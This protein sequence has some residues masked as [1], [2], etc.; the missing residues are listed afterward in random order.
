VKCEEACGN[1]YDP[2]YAQSGFPFYRSVG[3][4]GGGECCS[5]EI[6]V[7][8][9][10]C[11]GFTGSV[12]RDGKSCVGDIACFSANI[13]SVVR[14]CHGRTSCQAA[15]ARDSNLGKVIDSCQGDF[16]CTFAAGYK[17]FSNI[18]GSIEEI[19]GSCKGTNACQRAA[20]S[21]SIKSIIGSCI[22]ESSCESIAQQGS[23][24]NIYKSCNGTSACT[25]AAEGVF[26]QGA[27]SSSI[28]GVGILNSCNSDKACYDLAKTNS[29]DIYNCTGTQVA[30]FCPNYCPEPRGRFGN[31]TA[32]NEC[33]DAYCPNPFDNRNCYN[34]TEGAQQ[35][36]PYCPTYRFLAYYDIDNGLDS[37]CNSDFE[38]EGI[39]TQDD[40]P[41]DCSVS[42]D[43]PIVATD[44]LSA[45]LPE[46]FSPGSNNKKKNKD[47]KNAP[48]K[49]GKGGD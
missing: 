41:D 3:G 19:I 26:N 37:C 22:G 9:S 17:E 45:K 30:P 46:D 35:V 49:K 12:C 47:K 14:S 43:L 16:S 28:G 34:C 27:N 5:G 8:T 1:E 4:W 13:S 31:I 25:A 11:Q 36:Y 42:A 24:E 38:C 15:G 2:D 44:I 29:T 48:W 39:K 23:I 18:P 6:Y 20:S 21:G 33:L 32:Y 7:Y 40:L 10:P